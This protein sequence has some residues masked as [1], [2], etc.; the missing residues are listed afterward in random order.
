MSAAWAQASDAAKSWDACGGAEPRGEY[1]RGVGTERIALAALGADGTAGP[2]YLRSR[3]TRA[4]VPRQPLA[5]A[6]Y[7]GGNVGR[8][9]SLGFLGFANIASNLSYICQQAFV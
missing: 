2:R 4:R 9:W 8:P 3:I 5:A 1:C 6:R 7:S